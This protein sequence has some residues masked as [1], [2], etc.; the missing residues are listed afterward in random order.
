MRLCR[1]H[2]RLLIPLSLVALLPQAVAD[3]AVGDLGV[4]GIHSFADLTKLA[5]IPLT[6]AINLGGEALYSGII[7]AVAL[8]WRAGVARPDLRQIARRIPYL[9]LIAADAAIAVGTAVGL[10]LLIV[11]GIMFIT[12]TFIAPPLIE[13]RHLGLRAAMRESVR[14]VRGNFWRVLG[15][16]ALFYGGTELVTSLLMLPFH[17]F[18]TEAIAHLAIETVLEPF[19]GVAAVIIALGLLEIHGE[20]TVAPGAERPGR[21]E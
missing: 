16:A 13:V 3:A 6:V 21:R 18:E 8:H 10:A 9:T 1:R 4:E 11:P 17:D 7:A 19:Q 14:L 12:Y 5:T 15:L 2:W 20:P